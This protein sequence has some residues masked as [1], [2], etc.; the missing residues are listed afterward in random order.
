MILLEFTL[1]SFLIYFLTIFKSEV[2][3]TLL[4]ITII[5]LLLEQI[6]L[7]EILDLIFFK[8]LLMLVIY[9]LNCTIT[10]SVLLVLI[11]MIICFFNGLLVV[12]SILGFYF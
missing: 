4:V 10:L 5:S 3:A 1:F 8:S 12:I 2:I 9:I 11:G 6:E 7:T